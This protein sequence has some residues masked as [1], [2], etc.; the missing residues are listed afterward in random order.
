MFKRNIFLQAFLIAALGVIGHTNAGTVVGG[1]D[2]GSSNEE[3]IKSV[4]ANNNRALQG[5]G[6]GKGKGGSKG[7]GK[8]KGKGG[9]VYEYGSS[10][11]YSGYGK[12]KGKGGASQYGSSYGYY[13]YGKGKGKGGASQYGSSYGYSG[14]GKGKGKGGGSAYG[15]DSGYVIV[16]D[17]FTAPVPAPGSAPVPAP[18]SGP[19]RPGNAPAPTTPTTNTGGNSGCIEVAFEESFLF[20]SADLAIPPTSSDPN[21]I[22]TTFIYEPSPLFNDTEFTL[23]GASVELVDSQVTGVCTRTL[24]T[25]DS[26][27]GGGVCQFTIFAEGSYITFGGFVEDYVA[28]ST[29]PTL[30]ISGGSSFNTG[31]TGE[32]A[33]LPLDANGDA[34]TGDF[35]FDAF[36]YQAFTS[37]VMLVCEVTDRV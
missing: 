37:G 27:S 22:G 5:K 9:S 34:F 32:V 16:G 21:E 11:G 29:P 1:G 12:G 31:I 25:V 18:G 10:Y 2:L 20:L 15:Y 4:L 23:N 35:F 19:A 26:D 33:L 24:S 7:K 30:V 28:G 36:G 6:K 8:G 14:Y 17:D 13:G 3:G